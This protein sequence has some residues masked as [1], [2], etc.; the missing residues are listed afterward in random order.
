[1]YIKKFTGDNLDTIQEQIT[2]ELGENAVILTTRMIEIGLIQ[3]LFFGEEYEVTVGVDP[4]DFHEHQAFHHH[5]DDGDQDK[6]RLLA[7]KAM[8]DLEPVSARSIDPKVMTIPITGPLKFSVEKKNVVALVGHSH[9]GKA[10]TLAKFALKL[11]QTTPH[12][13][14]VAVMANVDPERAATV[15]GLARMFNIEYAGFQSAE[16]LRRFIANHQTHDIFL[17]DTPGDADPNEILPFL[18]GDVEPQVLLVLSAVDSIN[19]QMNAVKKY[20]PLNPTGLIVTN[21]LHNPELI[22]L[23]QL[24]I[25]EQIPFAYLYEGSDMILANAD[26]LEIRIINEKLRL[27]SL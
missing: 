10:E 20:R 15:E 8:Y 25:Q 19:Y 11:Q 21:L 9:V 24:A 5:T 14:A 12:K 3:S 27:N 16:E 13:V 17:I 18:Q 1:M 23:S 7:M 26:D 22:M 2:D 6:M 4:E